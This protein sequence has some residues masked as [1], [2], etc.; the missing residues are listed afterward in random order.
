MLKPAM[1]KDSWQERSN[2]SVKLNEST[3]SIIAFLPVLFY[4]LW[5]A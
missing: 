3:V 5:P 4:P 2:S 1:L